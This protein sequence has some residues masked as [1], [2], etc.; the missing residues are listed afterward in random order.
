M[1]SSLRVDVKHDDVF[2]HAFC[3]GL[4]RREILDHADQRLLKT[5]ESFCESL[6]LVACKRSGFA[7]LDDAEKPLSAGCVKNRGEPQLR[8]LG[9]RTE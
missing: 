9:A 4:L 5:I 6:D 8:L 3:S 7:V 2:A 1:F